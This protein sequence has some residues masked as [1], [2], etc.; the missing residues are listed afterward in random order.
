MAITLHDASAAL[1]IQ[2]LG[3]VEGFLK[4]GQAH[5]EDNNIPLGDILETRLF[6]DM[7][8]F[9]YQV[10]AA[11]GHSMGA[12]EAVKGGVFNPPYGTPTSDYG[13]LQGEVAAA[14][15][16]LK[17]YTPDEVNALEGNSVIFNLGDRQMPFTGE[18]FLL[19]FS[20]P[21]FH[22]HATTAYDILRSKGVPLGKRDYMG[23]IRL[24]T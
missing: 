12:I 14:L 3:A 5:F 21:N 16:K 1:F 8:P 24:K 2:T 18:G 7:L 23:R 6:S 19:T 11:I 13:A 17:S 20:L 9:R 22:F 10:Q 15:A 4:R